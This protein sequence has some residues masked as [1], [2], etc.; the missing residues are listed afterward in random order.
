MKPYVLQELDISPLAVINNVAFYIQLYQIHNQYANDLFRELI[1]PKTQHA[2][3]S[4]VS[5]WNGPP[6]PPCL[7]AEGARQAFN[8]L[9]H[10]HSHISVR[11]NTHNMLQSPLAGFQMPNACLINTNTDSLAHA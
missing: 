5:S 4:L 7:S 8:A 6:S 11:T 2:D 3:L 10:L 9:H 1:L